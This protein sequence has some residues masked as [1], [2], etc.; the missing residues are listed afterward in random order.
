[1]STETVTLS[2]TFAPA[3]NAPE[4]SVL[5]VPIVAFPQSYNYS[6]QWSIGLIV[7]GM[8]KGAKYDRYGRVFAET[9]ALLKESYRRYKH[10]MNLRG[11]NAWNTW[12]NK[13]ERP[14]LARL[15]R[16]VSQ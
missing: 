16:K 13:F 2:P 4:T 11:A 14:A 12:Y 15:G 10:S 1:M 5:S 7:A 3:E 6:M 9:F 8:M